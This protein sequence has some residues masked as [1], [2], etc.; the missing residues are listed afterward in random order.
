[1]GNGAPACL[2][3]GVLDILGHGELCNANR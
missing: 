3:G 2:G 1:V